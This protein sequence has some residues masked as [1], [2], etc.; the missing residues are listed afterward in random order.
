[1]NAYANT[2]TKTVARGVRQGRYRIRAASD[3]TRGDGPYDTVEMRAGESV[4]RG[5]NDPIVC[6][7][8]PIAKC[9][10]TPADTKLFEIIAFTSSLPLVAGV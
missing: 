7:S 10:A 4:A 9:A 6:R 2:F 5:V 3:E 1:V 8:G